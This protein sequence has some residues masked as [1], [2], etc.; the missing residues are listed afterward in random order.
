MIRDSLAED[1]QLLMISIE[2][3][4]YELADILVKSIKKQLT[5]IFKADMPKKYWIFNQEPKVYFVS[6]V[7]CLEFPSWGSQKYREMLIELG[8]KLRDFCTTDIAYFDGKTTFM[9]RGVNDVHFE[10]AKL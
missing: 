10:G 7:F 9:I 1:I 6:Q 3:K 2:I 5:G 4:E 8:R